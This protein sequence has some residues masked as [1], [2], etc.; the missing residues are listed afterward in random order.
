LANSKQHAAEHFGGEKFCGGTFDAMQAGTDNRITIHICNGDV[1]M[2]ITPLTYMEDSVP[3]HT[4]SKH[5][6]DDVIIGS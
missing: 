5:R 3:K 2:K 4:T 6:F 1:Q